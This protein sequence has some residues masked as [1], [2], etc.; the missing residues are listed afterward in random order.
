MALGRA[1]GTS[2]SVHQPLS[3]GNHHGRDVMDHC[4][5]LP[6]PDISDVPE[7][8]PDIPSTQPGACQAS[9]DP[10]ARVHGRVSL[11]FEPMP[12]ADRAK[13]AMFLL[14]QHVSQETSAAVTC[15]F[16]PQDVP[17]ATHAGYSWAM[18]RKPVPAW[19]LHGKGFLQ[20]CR[21]QPGCRRTALPKPCLGC[22]LR[23]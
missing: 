1:G 10:A 12:H 23:T 21:A 7:P 6:N 16:P 13:G 20:G 19:G 2:L 11:V 5:K 14:V 15:L 22:S 17:P 9:Q 3:C 8:L 4:W 18:I